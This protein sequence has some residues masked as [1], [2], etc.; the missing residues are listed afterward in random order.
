VPA[1]VIIGGQWGDEGKGKI[2]DLLAS[3]YSAVVRFSGGNNAGHTVIND[4]GEFK[5]HLIPS[6]ILHDNVTCII[7]NGCVIDPKVLIYEIDKLR[8]SGIKVS[9]KN[10]VISDKAHIILP[11]HIEKDSEQEKARG[12]LK[13]GTTGRGIGPA[14]MDK[15]AR[16]GYRMGSIAE[17]PEWEEKLG[18][19]ITSTQK[20][21]RDL[22]DHDENVLLEGAQGA[23][24]DIDHGSYPFVTSSNSTIGGA[25]TGTGLVPSDIRD[26]IG[27]FKAYATRVGE[28]PFPSEI[29][30]SNP[31]A[32]HLLEKGHEFGTTTGRERRCGWFDIESAKHSI[33]TNG[34][35]KIAIMKLDVLD[36]IEEINV[37]NGARYDTFPG[38]NESTFGIKNSSDLP[39]N[40]KNYLSYLKKELKVNIDIVSTG[41]ERDQTISIS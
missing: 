2:V 24:L 31:V 29:Q 34:F 11:R 21:L 16:S 15:V 6:G 10:L 12:N 19:H 32:K 13:I 4:L 7:G 30:K 33:M 27:I 38:W 28:G 37:L 20:L 35:N 9:S 8:A 36:G 18:S 23:L 22:L 25:L 5:L 1:D 3:K 39:E 40:A 17:W 41:P 26:T 14:Y